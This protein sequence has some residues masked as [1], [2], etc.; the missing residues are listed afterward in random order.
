MNQVFTGFKFDGLV[1]VRTA[2]L[3]NQVWIVAKDLVD[4]LGYSDT[5]KMCARLDLDEKCTKYVDL[6]SSSTED[7]SN[8]AVLVSES[9]LYQII[10][11]SKKPVARRFTK[12][13]TSE[14][15]PTLRKT[16]TYSAQPSQES[17]LS[18][19]EAGIRVGLQKQQALEHKARMTT[20]EFNG[21]DTMHKGLSTKQ[22]ADIT[23]EMKDLVS[24]CEDPSAMLNALE[25]H[26]FKRFP[27]DVKLFLAAEYLA[28][29]RNALENG[30]EFAYHNGRVLLDPRFT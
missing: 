16:G 12:W 2:V 10:F 4:V 9:G 28:R 13:V 3:D 6:G 26:F 7:L 14:V 18:L 25:T 23:Y 30:Y 22:W 20:A 5:N 11:G 19:V 1:E 21:P 24:E 29:V 8:N 27:G 17:F 15:L